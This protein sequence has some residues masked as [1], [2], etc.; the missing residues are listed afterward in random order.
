[1]NRLKLWYNQILNKDLIYKSNSQ[2]VLKIDRL[3]KVVL[4]CITNN[5]VNDAKNV[6]FVLVLMELLASQKP[7]VL[8]AK[9]SVAAF[10]LRKYV[11]LG[12]KITLRRF[13]MYSWIDLFFFIV[14]PKLADIVVFKAKLKEDA[15]VFDVGIKNIFS[16]PGLI[17]EHHSFAKNLG[18]TLTIESSKKK[19][20]HTV[21][22]LNGFQAPIKFKK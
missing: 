1:M 2:N 12:G 16:F 21:L 13:K 19:K 22:L 4:T 7:K 20:L 14:Q 8:R 5:V 11:A 10:K 17:Q 6:V 9:R 15:F 3:S 18:L